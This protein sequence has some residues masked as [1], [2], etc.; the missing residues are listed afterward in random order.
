MCDRNCMKYICK[1]KTD[2]I[3]ALVYFVDKG[4]RDSF[5]TYALEVKFLLC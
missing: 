3:S 5:V 2:K 4:K 1:V